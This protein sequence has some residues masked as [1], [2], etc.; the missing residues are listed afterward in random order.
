MRIIIPAGETIVN[1]SIPVTID[2][3]F[4]DTETLIW[5]WIHYQVQRILE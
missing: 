3:T 2:G 4:E 5:D 1:F